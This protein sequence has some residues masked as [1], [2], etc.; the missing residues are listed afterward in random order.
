MPTL[1]EAL[2]E[3]YG[4]GDGLEAQESQVCI[5]VPKLPPRLIVPELL[6]LND[7]DID[8]AGE[9]DDIKEKCRSVKELD[10]AQNKLQNWN[11][12]FK[13][14][15]HLP[16]VEFVNLSLNRLMGPI[17]QPPLNYSGMNKIRSLVLNNTHLNWESV[18]SLIR[19]LPVLE[20]LHLSLNDYS[21][22]LID[23]LDDDVFVDDEMVM[24]DDDHT[25]TCNVVPRTTTRSDSTCSTYKK[26]DAHEGVKKLHFTGN[27]VSEW[28]EICR[29][30]RVF[31]NL[32]SLVL[33][34]CPL[35]AVE[36]I[37]RSSSC[38]SDSDLSSEPSDNQDPP[39]AHFR[40]LAL[41]N[42]S[43]TH[44]NTWDDIDRLAKFPSLRNLR[45]QN[46]PLWEKCDSTEHE[47]R[48][49]LIARLPYVEKLNG[50]GVISS[51]EREDA[52]RAF[53]RYYLEKPELDRPERYNELTH[54]HGKLDRLVNI[55][56]RPDKRV[57][58]TFTY[59][60]TSEVRQVDV[61]RTVIDLK[62]RLERLLNIPAAKMRLFYVDK[63]LRDQGPEEMKYPH[64][65]LYS[66]N[67]S[68]GDEIIIDLK[69]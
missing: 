26:T 44:I 37:P 2:E 24:K 58:V 20:E 47:R 61:Y 10:L 8:K 36:P 15:T 6:V 3:K 63:D 68:T 17:E 27:P 54:I 11:E 29:L 40:N 22:V 34:D 14:L 30:G 57:K 52:E 65:Q 33:A 25:Y 69:R 32:E 48:Q 16:K 28:N 50:G 53:I 49:L 35:K 7:C 45:V 9:P 23:T 12:V 55:D 42:L 46:W 1:L 60:E 56:L 5:F 39:H 31:P 51:D 62:N 67:I 21:N 66:Y 64:K 13:I 19:M 41:L 38:G 59:G 18:E 43:S 4:L